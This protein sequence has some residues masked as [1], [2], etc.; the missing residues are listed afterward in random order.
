MGKYDH[1]DFGVPAGVREEAQRGL[2]W[3]KEHRRGGTSVGVATARTL[4]SAAN[5]SPEK[6]RHVTRYFPRHEVDKQGKGWSPGED[7][8]PSNGRI[9][10][11]LWGGDAAR[12]WSAKLVRQMDAADERKATEM[13]DTPASKAKRKPPTLARTRKRT[14]SSRAPSAPRMDLGAEDVHQPGP[15]K[16]RPPG[17]RRGLHMQIGPNG[18]I[19][20]RHSMKALMFD[21]LPIGDV[22]ARSPARIAEIEAA[23]P[24][25]D[26]ATAAALR[27][28]AATITAAD[29]KPVWIQ[30]A[31]VG[32]FAGHPAGP[33][34]L[35]E[36]V[37]AEIVRNFEHVD[38]GQVPIDFEHACEADAS[39]GAIPVAGAP[40]QGW[41]RA[42]DNRGAN[43]LWGLVEFLEPARSYIREG[44]YKGVSPSIRFGA[45]HPESGQLIGARLTSVALTNRPFLR[46]MQQVAARD[47]QETNMLNTPMTSHGE[48]MPRLRAALKLGELATYAECREQ[49]ARLR[50]MC[51]MAADPMGAHEGVNLGEYIAPMKSLMNMPAHM[52]L[53]EMFDAI[54]DMIEDAIERHELAYHST[55]TTTAATMADT[56]Q[57]DTAMADTKALKD[58]ETERDG[59]LAKLRDEEAKNAGLALQL[60]DMQAKLSDKDAEVSRLSSEVAA[61][62]DAEA[63]R[64]EA[65]AAARVEEA[66]STYKDLKKLT[67]ADKRAMSITLRADPSLFDQLYP[68]IAPNHAHVMRNLSGGANA[69]SGTGA[70]PV[71][72]RQ[73]AQVGAATSATYQDRVRLLT[74]KYRREGLSNEDA[75]AKAATEARTA[76]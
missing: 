58:I 55:D 38:H 22:V 66:F 49:L 63:K 61:L 24:T 18:T 70:Q 40:A 76:A 50:S 69:V 46:G 48:F 4:V 19:E 9:A 34:E 13:N 59:A 14:P 3:R 57:G 45:R 41:V 2:D 10:W 72:M 28:E 36:K 30:I 11:A 43:G 21:A 26:E 27:A 32:R 16:V 15:A 71:A 54:E 17:L 73:A 8:F 35:N 75:I 5:V 53:G 25:A 6:A 74:D 67:D 7:G 20:I 33:F 47:N 64:A 52:T 62:K 56:T 31:K 65:D 12:A 37:F 42:L 29:A 39:D 68:R 23:L 44:K 1:I 51:T 60:K